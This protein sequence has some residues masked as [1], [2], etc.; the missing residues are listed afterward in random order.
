M[1]LHEN[2][3]ATKMQMFLN[4][5]D[6]KLSPDGHNLREE[7]QKAK[8]LKVPT[9]CK[10]LQAHHDQWHHHQGTEQD[11]SQTVDFQIK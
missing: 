10:V 2:K 4:Y 9:A 5:E 11:L 6:S 8:D 7:Q 1:T 3:L